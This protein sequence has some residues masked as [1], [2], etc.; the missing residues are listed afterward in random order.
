MNIRQRFQVNDP[1]RCTPGDCEARLIDYEQGTLVIDVIDTCTDALAWR[2]WA[3][4][5]VQG[6]LENP[7]RVKRTVNEAVT[8][9][10]VLFPHA[11]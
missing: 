8:K 7:D 6:I 2:G 4:D 11:N 3:Q 10:M 9:M 1:E 5:G